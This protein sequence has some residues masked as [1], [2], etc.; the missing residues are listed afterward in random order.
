MGKKMDFLT[1]SDKIVN[2]VEKMLNDFPIDVY[3]NLWW[4]FA[5]RIDKKIHEIL[6]KS[7]TVI[8]KETEK[9]ASEMNK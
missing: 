2:D 3:A 7:V 8:D 6:E 1:E 9:L 4:L 5:T